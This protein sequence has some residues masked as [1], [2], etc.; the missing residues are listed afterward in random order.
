VHLGRLSV[1]RRIF[2]CRW[3]NSED[4]CPPQAS[5]TGRNKLLWIKLALY[6]GF[7]YVF[8][9]TFQKGVISVKCSKDLGDDRFC[10]YS[11]CNLSIKSYSEI[12][13]VVYKENGP[14][15]QCKMSLDQYIWVGEIY[16]LSLIF[17]DLYVS[18]LTPRLHLG[19]TAL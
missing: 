8:A 4:G 1:V 2:F 5:R 12:F 14:S 9:L 7:N 15:F 16:C 11:P 17:I 18:A 6:R 3:C 19:E 10:M 13:H